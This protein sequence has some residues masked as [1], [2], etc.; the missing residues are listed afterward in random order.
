MTSQGTLAAISGPSKSGSVEVAWQVDSGDRQLRIRWTETG[1]PTVGPPAR[2]GFGR[3]LL[4]RALAS[5]LG[6]D[7]QLDFA[8]NGLRCVIAIPLDERVARIP[9]S[10]DGLI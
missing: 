2:S 4:E 6:G 9:E 10:A 3:L 8:E 5:D 7:V 1:G